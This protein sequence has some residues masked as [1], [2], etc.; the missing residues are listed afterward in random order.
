[1]PQLVIKQCPVRFSFMI[2]LGFPGAQMV[3]NLPAVQEIWIWSLGREV[4]LKNGMATHS[5]VLAWR[6]PW[7][8]EPGWTTDHWVGHDWTTFTFVFHDFVT[9]YINN[10][11][12]EVFFFYLTRVKRYF[13]SAYTGDVQGGET[14]SGELE[15]GGSE[16]SYPPS[17]SP[18]AWLPGER[19]RVHLPL[20]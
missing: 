18:E 19:E 12:E 3:K 5:S 17:P 10:L 6:I 4:P 14:E 2:L 7:T 1:M 16:S 8:E 11:H 13:L 15:G 9:E 20:G